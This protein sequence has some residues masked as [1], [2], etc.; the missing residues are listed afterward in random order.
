MSERQPSSPPTPEQLFS[1]LTST[2]YH[3]DFQF[4]HGHSDAM[5]VERKARKIVG[6]I[7]IEDDDGPTVPIYNE[8]IIRFSAERDG[9]TK[10]YARHSLPVGFTI[11]Q[12]II[13]QV[14]MIPESIRSR[15]DPEIV[16]CHEY[17]EP[18][19][20]NVMNFVYYSVL[21]EDDDLTI[22]RNIGYRLH[23]IDVV[24]HESSELIGQPEPQ[25]IPIAH[26]QKTIRQFEPIPEEA[27][28][29]KIEQVTYDAVFDQFSD[30]VENA[31]FWS[32]FATAREI[33]AAISILALVKHLSPHGTL[34]KKLLL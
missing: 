23:N 26:R 12:E 15:L 28:E 34:P 18:G 19:D 1:R 21:R 22:D 13:Q 11:Q 10:K 20:L 17:S 31:A 32:Q 2:A 25:L 7:A 16:E 6:R 8:R 4:A 27:V 24:M 33:D 3:Y 14:A 5:D 29:D 30:G 9:P